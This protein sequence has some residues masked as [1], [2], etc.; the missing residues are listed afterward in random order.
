VHPTTGGRPDLPDRGDAGHRALRRVTLGSGP[1][2][3]GSDRLELLSRLA[4]VLVLL[5]AVPVAL[6]AGTVAA[7]DAAQQARQQAATGQQVDAVLLD[8]SAWVGVDEPGALTVAV[9]ARWQGPDGSVHEGL[10]RVPRGS[11]AGDVVPIWVEASGEQTDR[12]LDTAGVVAAGLSA[13]LL[14][15]LALGALAGGWHL[16][17]CGVLEAH[18]SRQWAREWRRLE[19]RWSGRGDD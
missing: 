18:R 13:G 17:L 4:C 8:D 5:I 6:T 1:L 3:R 11:S 14:T 12:P 16:G 9:P 19:P 7:D 2:A 15:F 10:A